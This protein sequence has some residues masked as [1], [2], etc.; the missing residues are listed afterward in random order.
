MVSAGSEVDL[1]LTEAKKKRKHMPVRTLLQRLPTLLLKLKPCLMMSPLTVSNFLT[2]DHAF[3]LVVF[4]EASQVPPWDAVNCIYRGRQLVVAGDDKQLPPTAFFQRSDLGEEGY[5]ED[6][7]GA[8]EV[9]DSIL[10][11]CAALLDFHSLRWHYRSRHEHLISF[12]N[13]HFYSNQL[14][15]FPSPEQVSPLLG[16]LLTYVPEGVYDR[17]R[18]KT[19]RIEARKAVERLTEYLLDGTGRSVGLIAFSS[20]QQDA[21]MDEL[22]KERRARPELEALLVGDRLDAVF[23]KNLES[24]QGDE[25]DVILFSVG[26]GKDAGGRFTLQLGPLNSE[27]GHR[28]LNVAVTRARQQVEVVTSVLAHDFAVTE[29]TPPGVRRLR[30]YLE[31]AERGP[32]ALKSEIGEM[33]GDFESPFEEAVAETIR[34]L[35]Y[36][37]VPQVGVGGFRIDLGVVD[38]AAQGRFVLGVEC[39]GA[40]YH[41]T[42]TARDR[43]RL[44]EEV[45]RNLGWSIHR[46]WSWD[47]VRDRRREVERLDEAIRDAAAESARRRAR[48]EETLRRSEAD[49]ARSAE[50]AGRDEEARSEVAASEAGGMDAVAEAPQSALE[51]HSASTDVRERGRRERP[52]YDLSTRDGATGLSWVATYRRADLPPQGSS[53][54]FHESV[55]RR[56][57]AQLVRTLLRVE[58]PV[59]TSYVV[60][61]IAEA[62]GIQRAGHRVVAAVQQGNRPGSPGGR[63]RA[64]WR[65]CLAPRAAT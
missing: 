25:R 23:V 9:M 16:V 55:N 51:G 11:S 61:R 41:S 21:I 13:H 3:D 29:L 28:R 59:S 34:G 1:L 19:N 20:A 63:C 47:W 26:Y 46:I 57:Q 32:A 37:A 5:D 18:S 58:G 42:P 60:H 38:P 39:D 64:A 30:D 6:S 15:T 17:G 31:F 44:R 49:G 12:S 43:D 53:Y 33:G 65:L 40:T 56:V 22:E 35:G 54:E 48:L 50:L 10:D 2:A 27:G 8:E 14:V 45:L 62:W 52:V 7:E 24:V 36:D 4:D